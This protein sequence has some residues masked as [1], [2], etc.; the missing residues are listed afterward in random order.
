MFSYL[1]L[2]RSGLPSGLSAVELS[3]AH[4]ELHERQT[5]V[6]SASRGAQRIFLNVARAE[7]ALQRVL[8]TD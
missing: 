6:G 4:R 5:L 8:D 7:F 2:L 3:L 1:L